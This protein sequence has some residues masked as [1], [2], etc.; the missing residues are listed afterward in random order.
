M[1]DVERRS[2]SPDDIGFNVTR[3][4]VLAPRHTQVLAH[5]LGEPGFVVVDENDAIG[6][7]CSVLLLIE[8]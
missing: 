6:P 2:E 1:V 7:A 3:A 5:P 8:Q 4:W